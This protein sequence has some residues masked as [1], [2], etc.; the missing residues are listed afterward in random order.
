VQYGTLGKNF[1]QVREDGPQGDSIYT[2]DAGSDV[3][4]SRLLLSRS[5]RL[6]VPPNAYV[7]WEK[8][9]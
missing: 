4:F 5:G 9:C 8:M 7:S 3:F 6:Y 1:R 2:T